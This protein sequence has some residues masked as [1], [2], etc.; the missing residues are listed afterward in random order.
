MLVACD[1]SSPSEGA[2]FLMLSER[3]GVDIHA[4]KRQGMTI[5]EIVRHTN[6][7]RKTIRACLNG[8]RTVGQRKRVAPDPFDW[9]VG[10]VHRPACRGPALVGHD[11]AG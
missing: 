4:P 10:Y 9:F 7:D 11:A 8:E 2:L 1:H 6:R 3:S 5:S